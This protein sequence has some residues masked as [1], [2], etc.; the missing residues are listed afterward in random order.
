MN[1]DKTFTYFCENI[2]RLYEN[3]PSNT[4]VMV[5]RT[6]AI[7]DKMP[8]SAKASGHQMYQD[9][10]NDSKNGETGLK[11][12]LDKM[13]VNFGEKI[14]EDTK[15]SIMDS[16]ML[17]YRNLKDSGFNSVGAFFMALGY[18]TQVLISLL[19]FRKP[20]TKS[21]VFDIIEEIKRN[22][23]GY[24]F[25]N[26]IIG[27]LKAI[28][29]SIATLG[30]GY[31]YGMI[32]THIF[33]FI[34]LIKVLTATDQ[35]YKNIENKYMNENTR[36]IIKSMQKYLRE[37]NSYGFLLENIP[38]EG[39]SIVYA[40]NDASI[41]STLKSIVS[42]ASTQNPAPDQILATCQRIMSAI[43]ADA[44][45]KGQDLF[46]QSMVLSKQGPKSLSMSLD[47]FKAAYGDSISN[48]VQISVL[49]AMQIAYKRLVEAKYHPIAAWFL[50]ES[51]MYD[52]FF[53]ILF[54]QKPYDKEQLFQITDSLI[55]HPISTYFIFFIIGYCKAFLLTVLTVGYGNLY[56]FLMFRIYK[57]IFIIQLLTNT[58][59]EYDALERRYSESSKLQYKK[60]LPNKYFKNLER[61]LQLS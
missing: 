11:T 38:V 56:A 27:L 41:L 12:Q 15:L 39:G 58:E 42:S 1:N 2:V 35:T 60:L 43:P 13:I 24:F 29:I 28:G 45:V 57:L 46:K 20:H 40:N 52:A 22:P 48:D 14:P 47:N 5:N 4:D 34:F 21:E 61:Y 50:S 10:I 17:I 9:A 26:I 8:Q 6:M 19:V 54:F 32:V 55:A 18:F 36:R 30:I 25:K 33:C 16:G 23:V 53:S 49:D 31:I 3:D 7:M 51:L 59:I 44:K 37:K